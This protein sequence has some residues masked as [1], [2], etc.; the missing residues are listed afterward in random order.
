[1]VSAPSGNMYPIRHSAGRNEELGLERVSLSRLDPQYFL[2]ES[3]I[4][5]R[6]LAPALNDVPASSL[7]D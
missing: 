4:T 1:M 2:F 7:G 5:V 6:T 3:P